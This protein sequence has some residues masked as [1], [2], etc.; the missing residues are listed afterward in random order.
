MSLNATY[1]SYLV[2]FW[3]DN[4]HGAWRASIQS[5]TDAE[6]FVFAEMDGLFDFLMT[7]LA[8]EDSIP[9]SPDFGTLESTTL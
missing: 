6:K 8:T 2:R 5:T 4:A 7:Q 3:R 9:A 1:Q